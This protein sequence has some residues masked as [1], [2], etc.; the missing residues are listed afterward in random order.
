MYREPWVTV[1]W[2]WET[3]QHYLGVSVQAVIQGS[4]QWIL[5]LATETL[6]NISSYTQSLLLPILG[7]SHNQAAVLVLVLGQ[8]QKAVGF[9]WVS[10]QLALTNPCLQPTLTLPALPQPTAVQ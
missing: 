5:V 9:L 1:Q 6:T 3:G 10:V 2:Y 4:R 7:N 8:V